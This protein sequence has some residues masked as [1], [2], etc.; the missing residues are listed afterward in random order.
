MI[1]WEEWIDHARQK[2]F[3]K[4]EVAEEWLSRAT[5]DDLAQLQQAIEAIK[6]LSGPTKK[7]TKELTE[8]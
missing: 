7:L 5:Q 6:E 1:H 2:R 3:F 4:V 8:Q